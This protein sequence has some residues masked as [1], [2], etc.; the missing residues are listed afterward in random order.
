MKAY[1]MKRGTVVEHDGRIWQI[2]DVE[3]S[4]PT[5]RGGN[6]TYRFAMYS[7]PGDVKLDLSLR[8]DDDLPEVELTRRAVT[9]ASMDGDAFVFL[10]AADYTPYMLDPALVGENAGYIT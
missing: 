4:A 2:K 7:V 1:D 8:A 9:F 5:G 6:T 10:D 3:R